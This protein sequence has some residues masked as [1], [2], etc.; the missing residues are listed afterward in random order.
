MMSHQYH[1]VPSSTQV[2]ENNFH[3]VYPRF[4][5]WPVLVLVKEMLNDVKKPV[6]A[7]EEA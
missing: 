4:D 2:W 7:V 1:T 3:F 6:V 5:H